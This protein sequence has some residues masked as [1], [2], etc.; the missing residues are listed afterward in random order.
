MNEQRTYWGIQC[1]TCRELIAFDGCPYVS[2][3]P[4]AASL[5]PGAICC[6]QGHNHIYFPRDF[7]FYP[8]Q[9]LITEATMKGN[10][11]IYAEIN[12]PGRVA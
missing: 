10:R 6:N 12:L 2:F 7:C 5:K 8:S 3:G 4:R 9:T 1:R 11:T